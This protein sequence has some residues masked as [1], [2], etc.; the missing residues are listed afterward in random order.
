MKVAKP[1]TVTLT[2]TPELD[3]FA[4]LIRFW[5]RTLEA[6]GKAP[7]TRRLYRIVTEQLARYLEAQGMP[8]AIP[9][10][11]REHV[12][13]FIIDQQ[14][15]HPDTAT[16]T[17]K[18][19]VLR[20]FFRWLVEEGELLTSPMAR[21]HEPKFL[22]KEVPVL[23]DQVIA[24][25]LASCKGPSFVDRRD[26][27]LLRVFVDTPLRRAEVANLT[28]ADV[29]LVERELHVR[30]KGN[31]L[32]TVPFGVKTTLALDRY[33]RVRAQHPFASS[34]RFWL[35][36][37]GGLTSNGVYWVLGR[38]AKAVGIE[39]LHPHLFRHKFADSYLRAEGQSHDLMKLGG[40]RS[41]EVMR[42]YAE[43]LAEERAILAYRR[44]SLGDRF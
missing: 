44:L 37:R 24:Q 30:V 40:W 11:T 22:E 10:L 29:D 33:R 14:R 26:L 12:E 25:L 21:M 42:K 7:T 5:L 20:A 19:K 28:T 31:R 15:Q 35:G 41:A 23:A 3:E 32:R 27:A 36:E 6:G 17:D 9:A 4:E 16:A 39:G 2:G 38:R 1:D 34:E 8:L 18:F 43:N 13:C